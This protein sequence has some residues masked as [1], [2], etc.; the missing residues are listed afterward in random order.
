MAAHLAAM[1]IYTSMIW[2]IERTTM[3]RR[4][5]VKVI[6]AV[7]CV[8]SVAAGLSGCAHGYRL[9]GNH[10]WSTPS[11]GSKGQAYVSEQ[12]GANPSS[13]NTSFTR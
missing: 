3:N 4:N 1:A 12:N 9:E 13:G 11:P 6:A 10:T 8:G 5:L 2:R 7:I